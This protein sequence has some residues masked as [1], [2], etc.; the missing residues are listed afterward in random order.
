MGASLPAMAQVDRIHSQGVSR[1]GLLYGANTA[2]AVL[3]CLAAGFYLLR[4][5]DM[6]TATVVAA[7]INGL[8]A[9]AQV[10]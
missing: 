9:L 2:G 6:P 4:V 1:L 7:A 8:V 10:S 5:F 3:G